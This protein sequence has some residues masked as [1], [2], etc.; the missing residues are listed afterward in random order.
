MCLDF[1]G[2][3][4]L[5]VSV[6]VSGSESA[7]LPSPS[8]FGKEVSSI[9]GEPGLTTVPLQCHDSSGRGAHSE[10]TSQHLRVFMLRTVY[11]SSRIHKGDWNT[12]ILLG[13]A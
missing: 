12:R 1:S 6:Y 2:V 7:D 5:G 4:A 9:Q 10:G 13:P 11:T 8:R 3:N